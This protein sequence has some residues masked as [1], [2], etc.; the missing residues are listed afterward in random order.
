VRDGVLMQRD[1]SHV[2]D[3]AM[4]LLIPRVERELTARHVLPASD[5]RSSS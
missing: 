5:H 3:P 2:T 1:D 4:T